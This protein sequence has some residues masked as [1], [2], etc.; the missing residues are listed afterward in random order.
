MTSLIAAL[1]T[2][3]PTPV[4]PATQLPAPGDRVGPAPQCEPRV[5]APPV[6]EP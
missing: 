1:W 2:T 4:L 3:T 5:S 6:E